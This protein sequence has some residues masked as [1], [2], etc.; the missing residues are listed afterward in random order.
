ML[1]H[2]EEQNRWIE[3]EGITKETRLC[4]IIVLLTGSEYRNV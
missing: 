4:I 3:I 2:F 1:N